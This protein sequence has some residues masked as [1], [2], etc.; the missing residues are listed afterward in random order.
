MDFSVPQ[1]GNIELMQL[2][3]KNGCQGQD[4]STLN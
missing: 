1:S 3:V 4:L 2:F